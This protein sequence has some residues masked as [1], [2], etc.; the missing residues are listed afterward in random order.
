[1]YAR[2]YIKS[3]ISQWNTDMFMLFIIYGTIK[4]YYIRKKIQRVL[5]YIITQIGFR[6]TTSNV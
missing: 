6:K 3:L 1:M 2:C 4:Y 5:R